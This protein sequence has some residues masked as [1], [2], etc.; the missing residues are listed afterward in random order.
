LRRD[1]DGFLHDLWQ[2]NPRIVADVCEAVRSK[3][4]VMSGQPQVIRGLL[5][6]ARLPRLG[7]ALS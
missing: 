3:A 2:G 4:E 5:K 7:K 6:K 1:P